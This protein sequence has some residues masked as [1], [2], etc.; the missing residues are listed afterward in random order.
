[1]RTPWEKLYIVCT[2]CL[3]RMHT[4]VNHGAKNAFIEHCFLREHASA[5]LKL[6][7][8]ASMIIKRIDRS[9][10]SEQGTNRSSST[11]RNFILFRAVTY[12]TTRQ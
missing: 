2:R 8:T 5:W 7:V 3:R 12:Y 6:R 4:Y 11:R 1:M 9:I 10:M